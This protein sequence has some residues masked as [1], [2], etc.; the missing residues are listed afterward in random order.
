MVMRHLLSTNRIWHKLIIYLSEIEKK[1]P[2]TSPIATW[3]QTLKSKGQE[4]DR[5]K[6]LITAGINSETSYC[7]LQKTFY[8]LKF[9]AIWAEKGHV[10]AQ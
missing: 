5:T 9:K 6:L 10:K 4:Q 8:R 3:E 2:K 7:L 1:K